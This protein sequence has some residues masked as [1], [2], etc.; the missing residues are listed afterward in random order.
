MH[1]VLASAGGS[2]R[3]ADPQLLLG[4]SADRRTWGD[5]CPPLDF[6][7]GGGGVV[8]PHAAYGRAIAVPRVVLAEDVRSAAGSMRTMGIEAGVGIAVRI[9]VDRLR[10][11]RSEWSDVALVDPDQNLLLAHR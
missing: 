9:S 6:A 10:N 7:S 2:Q 5:G 1:A 4:G 11:C 8:P 3:W